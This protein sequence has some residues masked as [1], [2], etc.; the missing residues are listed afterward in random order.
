MSEDIFKSPKHRLMEE[1]F[2]NAVENLQQRVYGIYDTL[3]NEEEFNSLDDEGKAEVVK[4]VLAIEALLEEWS[5]D[6]LMRQR[7]SPFTD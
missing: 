6:P 7:L 3:P 4:R 2:S 1:I 5:L